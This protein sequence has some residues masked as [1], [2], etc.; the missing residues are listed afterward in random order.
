MFIDLAARVQ[1]FTETITSTL[2]E[3]HSFGESLEKGLHYFQRRWK[4]IGSLSFRT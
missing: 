3:L 2:L 1:T 4:L